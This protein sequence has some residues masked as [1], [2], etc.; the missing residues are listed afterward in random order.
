MTLADKLQQPFFP[1]FPHFTSNFN[2]SSYNLDGL[3]INKFNN[4]R[5]VQLTRNFTIY[6]GGPNDDPTEI[7]N[8]IEGAFSGIVYTDKN[9]NSNFEK[10]F[11]TKLADVR[12]FISHDGAYLLKSYQELDK[13]DN[14]EIAIF[15]E[16]PKD[17]IF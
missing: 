7:E 14:D 10:E 5:Q 4:F 6:T 17:D 12:L 13:I 15:L 1:N 9:R 11:D 3:A 8:Y 2:W 16:V